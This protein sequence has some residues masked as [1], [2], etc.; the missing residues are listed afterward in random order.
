VWVEA[1][2]RLKSVFLAMLQEMRS[3]YLLTYSPSGVETGG[4]HTLTVRLKNK[5]GR[6]IARRGYVAHPEA[7]R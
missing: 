4:W 5:A 1:T 3:R 7:S 2:E 6:V